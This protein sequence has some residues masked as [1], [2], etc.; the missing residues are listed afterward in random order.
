MRLHDIAKAK[1]ASVRAQSNEAHHREITGAY[2]RYHP[3]FAAVGKSACTKREMLQRFEHAHLGRH[4]HAP[5]RSNQCGQM[6][7]NAAK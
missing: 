2:W 7:P 6:R 4:R 5:S 1:L 3:R